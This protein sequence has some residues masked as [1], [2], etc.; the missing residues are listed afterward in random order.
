MPMVEVRKPLF[1]DDQ[2]RNTKSN[3]RF[4]VDWYDVDDFGADSV[5]DNHCSQSDNY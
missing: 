4:V 2:N 5:R 1:S 3:H